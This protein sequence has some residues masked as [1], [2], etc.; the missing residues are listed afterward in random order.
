MCENP[1]FWKQITCLEYLL[2]THAC[3]LHCNKTLPSVVSA[4][5]FVPFCLQTLATIHT[6]H[7]HWIFVHWLYFTFC[8]LSSYFPHENRT[9]KAKLCFLGGKTKRNKKGSIIARSQIVLT[10]CSSLLSHYNSSAI[11]KKKKKLYRHKY[12]SQ[13]L[14]LNSVQVPY[15]LDCVA[16]AYWWWCVLRYWWDDDK[17]KPENQRIFATSDL[18]ETKER[19]V[20]EETCWREE[21]LMDLNH[22]FLGDSPYL[23]TYLL[24]MFS[25]YCWLLSTGYP[26]HIECVWS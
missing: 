3:E 17:N 5:I 23:K 21:I 10:S 1:L 6:Q 13:F 24:S 2:S 20:W 18:G 25:S 26:H 15:N 22:I 16:S 9:I 14:Q 8:F 4:P 12:S 19:N 11:L 7:L